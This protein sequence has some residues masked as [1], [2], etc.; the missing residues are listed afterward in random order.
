[1]IQ[2]QILK[3]F[4]DEREK[5]HQHANQNIAKI[6]AKNQQTNKIRK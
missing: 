5:Q 6:Q 4:A 3:S 2:Q 1:V